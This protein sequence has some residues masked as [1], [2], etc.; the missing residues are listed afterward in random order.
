[1]NCFSW[2]IVIIVRVDYEV[3]GREVTINKVCYNSILKVVMSELE[4]VEGFC[5][6]LLV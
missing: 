5:T 1:M 2:R 4:V 3:V 6:L